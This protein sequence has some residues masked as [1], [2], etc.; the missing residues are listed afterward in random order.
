MRLTEYLMLESVDWNTKSE[1]EQ[2]DL[3][4]KDGL[5]IRHI[6]HPSLAVQ[7]AAIN[8]YSWAIRYI[9]NPSEAI[10]LTAVAIAAWVVR[11]I[12]NPT[13]KV[14]LTAL[15]DLK[16][17]KDE[18]EYNGFVKKYFANNTLLMKKWLRYGEAMR[19]QE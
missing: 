9:K 6:E 4:T 2:I 10:Q 14:L 13:T 17:I 11:Y 19:G 8:Q 7:M 1:K 5:S 12:D 15:K 18:E 16:F 3:V